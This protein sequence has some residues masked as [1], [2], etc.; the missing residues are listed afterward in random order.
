MNIYTEAELAEKNA[1]LADWCEMLIR[2]MQKTPLTGPASA[3]HNIYAWQVFS[4]Q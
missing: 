4:R 2:W 1:E 3:V